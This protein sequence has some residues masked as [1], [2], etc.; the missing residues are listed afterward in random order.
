VG[1]WGTAIFSD[2]LAADIRDGWRALIGDGVAPA[3]ATRRVL[4]D[5][6]SS[7]DDPDER[8]VVWLALAVTQW[9]TGRLVDSVRDT[10]VDIIDSGADL[11]RW[12]TPP[13]R[14]ARQKVLAKAREQ[15]LSPQPPAKRLPKPKQSVTPYGP[16]DLIGYTHDSGARFLLWVMANQTDQDGEYNQA[17]V[18]DHVGGQLPD[19]ITASRLPAMP[20]SNGPTAERLG[21]VLIDAAKIP[22]GRA[23]LIGNVPRPADRPPPTLLIVNVRELDDWLRPFL[24]GGDH[25]PRRHPAD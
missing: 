6:S 13:E 19:P 10:A 8:S 9:K 22:A 15:L 11:A 4:A 5:Y 12:Q 23:D 21:F 18:L 7:V 17:E 24:P 16:G 25:I 3:D 14:K 1:T 20:L 2:D